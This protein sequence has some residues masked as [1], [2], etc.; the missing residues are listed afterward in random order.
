MKKLISG[1][2]LATLL[3]CSLNAKTAITIGAG[4]VDIGDTSN[5]ATMIGFSSIT[6]FK[7]TIFEMPIKYYKLDDS[8]MITGSFGLS[9]KFTDK[10]YLGGL[11]GYSVLIPDDSNQDGLGG[12]LTGITAGYKIA[13]NHKLSLDII[14]ST[15]ENGDN[16]IEE[17]MSS[18]TLNYTYTFSSS[19]L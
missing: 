2:A 16:T 18:T 19:N 5:S 3:A 7:T 8:A 17:D 10:L 1:V 14:S 13:P 15:L 6:N 11:L 9:Y 12:L 4:N